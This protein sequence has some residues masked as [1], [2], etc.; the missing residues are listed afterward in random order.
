MNLQ[1]ALKIMGLTPDFSEKELK[2]KYRELAKKYHPDHNIGNKEALKK[3]QETNAAHE[4]L[5][6]TLGKPKTNTNFFALK[7]EFKNKISKYLLNIKITLKD[8]DII[9]IAN[10]INE[11]IANYIL[12]LDLI[13]LNEMQLNQEYKKVENIIKQK[14]EKLKQIIIEK[15]II[16]CNQLPFSQEAELKNILLNAIKIIDVEYEKNI[17]TIYHETLKKLESESDKITSIYL[18]ESLK[19]LSNISGKYSSNKS[20]KDKLVQLVVEAQKEFTKKIDTFKDRLRAEKELKM[21]SI[22]F[23]NKVKQEIIEKLDVKN[24]NSDQ[25]QE[26]YSKT[27]EEIKRT[28]IKHSKSLQ[29]RTDNNEE[30][31]IISFMLKEIIDGLQKIEMDNRIVEFLDLIRD[32]DIDNTVSFYQ[33]YKII[34][35][36]DREIE[37]MHNNYN[38]NYNKKHL[39]Q[40][41]IINNNEKILRPRL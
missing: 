28:L 25:K 4:Y 32:I 41:K 2:E 35:R 27:L 10:K 9:D 8:N 26:L 31:L 40:E 19:L 24:K 1:K 12:L 15:L 5:K 3:M 11:T 13:K 16:K 22:I 6:K 34:R 37:Y 17:I 20:D 7:N 29:E 39:Y 33:I 38:Y 30:K 18:N 21:M 36:M 14:Y 23:E